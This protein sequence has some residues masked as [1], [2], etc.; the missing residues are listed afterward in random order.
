VSNYE[1][2]TL[3]GT[4]K[5]VSVYAIKAYW[6]LEVKLHSFL[7]LELDE[8]EWKASHP[9]HFTIRETF[10]GAFFFFI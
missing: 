5:V 1:Q 10:H 6:G 7:A 4:S 9:G 3:D 8:S 2:E